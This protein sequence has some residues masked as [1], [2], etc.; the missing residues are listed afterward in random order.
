MDEEAKMA[1]MT[2]LKR[3]DARVRKHKEEVDE[4]AAAIVEALT[5]GGWRPSEVDAVVHYDRN[6]VRRIA[7]KA[8]VPPLR[9]PR[10]AS[11]PTDL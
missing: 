7:K 8:G 1:T 4:L 9:E 11:E 10:A 5:V 6:H 3:A 2:R